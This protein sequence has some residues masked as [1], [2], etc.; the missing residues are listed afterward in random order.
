MVMSW[1]IGRRRLG[2]SDDQRIVLAIGE[3]VSPWTC[4][5]IAIG[6]QIILHR[7]ATAYRSSREIQVWRM[8]HVVSY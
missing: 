7:E 6:I 3:N 8:G 5:A 2:I 1:K 4:D